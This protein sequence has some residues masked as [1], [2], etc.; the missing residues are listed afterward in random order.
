MSK[1]KGERGGEGRKEPA[2]EAWELEGGVDI[3]S[4][5]K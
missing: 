2:T 5:L 3:L 4:K 1:W